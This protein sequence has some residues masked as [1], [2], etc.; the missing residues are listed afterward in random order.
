MGFIAVFGCAANTPMTTVILGIEF[1]GFQ[2]WPFY[3]IAALVSYFVSGHH[4][5]YGAQVIHRRKH[6]FRAK[7]HGKT[8]E[9]LHS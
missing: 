9:E 2:A 1:F 8:L 5:I 3:V 7:V 6:P 4:G